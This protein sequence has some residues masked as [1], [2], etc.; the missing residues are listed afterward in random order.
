[1]TIADEIV[2]AANDPAGLAFGDEILEDRLAAGGFP[3][4]E[5]R[6]PEILWMAPR[7]PMSLVD[8]VGKEV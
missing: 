3:L 2:G 8:H 1:M 5:F 7:Q 4:L 6:P